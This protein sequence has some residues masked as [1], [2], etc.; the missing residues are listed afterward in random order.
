MGLFDKLLRVVHGSIIARTA[1]TAGEVYHGH[2]W[3]QGQ[4]TPASSPFVLGKQEVSPHPVKQ[5]GCAERSGDTLAQPDIIKIAQDYLKGPP[6]PEPKVAKHTRPGMADIYFLESLVKKPL[7]AEAALPPLSEEQAR[8]LEAVKGGVNVFFT[9]PAGSGKTLLVSHIKQYLEEQNITFAVTAPTGVAALLL[10]GNTIHSW[11]GLGRGDQPV[12]RYLERLRH[13]GSNA[14]RMNEFKNTKV[15]IIDEVSMLAPD[16]FRKVSAL[17]KRLRNKKE[18]MGGMQVIVTGDF[19]QLPPVVIEAERTCYE[20]GTLI[21]F[22]TKREYLPHDDEMVLSLD[23][24]LEAMG[25][26]NIDWT[27]CSRTHPRTNRICGHMWNPTMKYAYQT[28]DWLEANFKDFTLTKVYRQK[29]QEWIDM[30]AKI[31]KGE[32]FRDGKISAVLDGLKRP[33]PT[34]PSG[35]KPTILHT[36]RVSSEQENKREYQKLDGAEVSY[37]AVDSGAHVQGLSDHEDK[38]IRELKQKDFIGEPFFKNLAAQGILTLKPRSQVMLLTNLS[39]K[40]GLVNGSRG[41]VTS[42]KR[43]SRVQLESLG[44]EKLFMLFGNATGNDATVSIPLVTFIS[45]PSNPSLKLQSIPIVP[46]I[47]DQKILQ[48]AGYYLKLNRIQLPLAFA[49]AT[50]IHKC[51]GMSL[52]YATINIEKTFLPGQGY[53]AISRVRNT[54]G[55]QI[56]GEYKNWERV[57]FSDPSVDWFLDHLKQRKEDE[58]CNLSED[59]AENSKVEKLGF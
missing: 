55:L 10:G 47:F 13:G 39:I 14:S 4:E 37:S 28:L 21:D 15:L 49:W 12:F 5:E 6:V 41:I 17:M 44:K 48:P 16:L 20:C 31:K 24:Y 22:N 52:D 32:G 42:F 2:A 30:L 3:V 8:I 35:I 18:F 46:H 27:T 54:Q 40:A 23:P 36:H 53:V 58:A 43:Y 45:P 26:S 9:G 33:L 19:F 29:D 1:K 56:I 59:Q 51:Q 57:F 11:A 25:V 34:L 38:I 7:V 50:T